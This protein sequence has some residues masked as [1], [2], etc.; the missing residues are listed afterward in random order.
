MNDSKK[1][2]SKFV[3]VVILALLVILL[4]KSRFALVAV[5]AIICIGPGLLV[6]QIYNKVHRFLTRN[7][8]NEN[9]ELED[10]NK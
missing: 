5:I 3:T 4:F 2:I 9:N 1:G 6:S 7:D 10:V 8:I